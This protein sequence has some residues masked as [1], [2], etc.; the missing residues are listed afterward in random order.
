VQDG[1]LLAGLAEYAG[2]G[3]VAVARAVV[4]GAGRL[5]AVVVD[6]DAAG[7]EGAFQIGQ[8]L[9]AVEQ[10]DGDDRIAVR[11]ETVRVEVSLYPVDRQ[12]SFGG[13]PLGL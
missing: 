10:R 8:S 11:R 13:P 4:V 6:E 7:F 3:P 12:R 9:A 5:Q 2:R 1:H